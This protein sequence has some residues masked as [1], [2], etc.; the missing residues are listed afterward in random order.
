M[1]GVEILLAIIQ[2]G[3]PWVLVIM[4][5]VVA[6]RAPPPTNEFAIRLWIA[7]FAIVALIVSAAG[8]AGWYFDRQDQIK[9]NA[10]FNKLKE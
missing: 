3:G 9:A 8:G 6:I 10:E 2:Y 4:G 5:A 7:A 1:C